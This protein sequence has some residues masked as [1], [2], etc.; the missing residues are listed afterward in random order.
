MSNLYDGP[1]IGRS[2]HQILMVFEKYNQRVYYVLGLKINL[3]NGRRH[4]YSECDQDDKVSVF[5]SIIKMFDE[6]IP[7]RTVR[8]HCTDKPWMTTNIKALI[9]ERQKAFCES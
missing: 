1:P 7:V 3:K 2:D 6:T 4:A 8:G 5:N 9:K